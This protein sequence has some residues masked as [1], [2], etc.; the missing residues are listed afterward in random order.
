MSQGSG[1]PPEVTLLEVLGQP[2]A[3][4]DAA[5]PECLR[6]SADYITA[7]GNYTPWALQSKLISF[8]VW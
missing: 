3:P 6:D 5:S 4:T 7:L 2:L 1:V 8:D